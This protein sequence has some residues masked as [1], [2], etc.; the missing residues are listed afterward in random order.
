MCSIEQHITNEISKY[1]GILNWNFQHLYSSK[2]SDFF[3][4]Q[5]PFI[6]LAYW[7]V[8]TAIRMK[9]RQRHYKQ[10]QKGCFIRSA[11][12]T[13]RSIQNRRTDQNQNVDRPVDKNSGQNKNPDW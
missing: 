3:S 7:N 8:G 9:R 13:A 2:K 11:A 4:V 5:I 10:L 6:L 1:L 12:E